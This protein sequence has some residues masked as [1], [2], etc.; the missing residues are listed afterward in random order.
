[1][2]IIAF[3]QDK[4]VEEW[5]FSLEAQRGM[6]VDC[7]R[8]DKAIDYLRN[9]D[10]EILVYIDM[11]RLPGD[12]LKRIMKLLEKRKGP[13]GVIDFDDT[14]VDPAWFFFEG[15][16]D[17]IGGKLMLA[18]PQSSR[19]KQVVKYHNGNTIVDDKPDILQKPVLNS[20]PIDFP[21]WSMVKE[22]EEYSFYLA[23]VELANQDEIRKKIGETRFN[24]LKQTFVQFI[25]N[26][27]REYDALPWMNQDVRTLLL[28]PY[29]GSN[30]HPAPLFLRLFL[31]RAVYSYEKLGLE[32]PV[33]FKIALHASR[34]LYREPGNTGTIVSDALNSIFHIGQKYTNASEFCMTKDAF[35]SLPERMERLF[36]VKGEFEG[37]KIHVMYKFLD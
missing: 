34:V 33:T 11:N 20:L 28:I 8:F 9:C 37:K 6:Q 12:E 23:Y 19:F 16:S 18:P 31:N 14:F 4:R 21:G 25:G 36:K 10:R 32:I 15:A 30:N 2:K 27:M 35:A 3:T 13:W 7:Q 1:M 22:G 17:F 29:R 26:I 5:F 24:A